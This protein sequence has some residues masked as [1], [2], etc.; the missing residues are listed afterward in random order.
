MNIK[1]LLT[2]ARENISQEELAD[3]IG[4]ENKKISKWE[5]GD[6]NPNLQELKILSCFFERSI[7]QIVNDPYLNHKKSEIGEILEE[8]IEFKYILF[9]SLLLIELVLFNMN[10]MCIKNNTIW[11]IVI[12]M[13]G[14]IFF[15]SYVFIYMLDSVSKILLEE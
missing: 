12:F 1:D 14:V 4:I 2:A 7:S 8:E 15:I 6:F 5:M 3:Q 9:I 10:I 11:D 13:I